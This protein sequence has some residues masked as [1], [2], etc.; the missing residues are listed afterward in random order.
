MSS[1]YF[2]FYF[3]ILAT[4]TTVTDVKTERVFE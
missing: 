4:E 1:F 2:L 3:T